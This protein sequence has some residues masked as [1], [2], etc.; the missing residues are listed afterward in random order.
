MASTSQAGRGRRARGALG[1]APCGS[2]FAPRV[3]PCC[4]EAAPS[5]W[6]WP[7]FTACH[8][9]RPAPAVWAPCPAGVSPGTLG[10][11]G[12]C[13]RQV[14]FLSALPDGLAQS[15]CSADD[16]WWPGGGVTEGPLPAGTRQG[17]CT[18]ALRTKA[19]SRS[20]ACGRGVS[21][22]TLSCARSD[23]GRCRDTCV[24]V[25]PQLPVRLVVR[26]R[27]SPPLRHP[28]PPDFPG[29][30]PC[31]LSGTVYSFTCLLVPVTDDVSQTRTGGVA[32]VTSC[33]S[34]GHR[35]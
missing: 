27:T 32:G 15:Q 34:L 14:W 5:L 20:V 26:D 4:L 2:K 9:P 3:P 13:V 22:A 35:G 12:P 10:L 7:S 18:R 19:R 31:G 6:P 28:H 33:C 29:F 23:T 21:G 25:T 1:A 16:R 30:C 8:V 17:P 11:E 24:R